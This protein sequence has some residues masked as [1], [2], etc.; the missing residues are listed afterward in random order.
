MPSPLPLEQTNRISETSLQK[1]ARRRRGILFLVLIVIMCGGLYMFVRPVM[2]AGV[3]PV[4]TPTQMLEAVAT[5]EPTKKV[6]VPVTVIVERVITATAA[7]TIAP[8]QTPYII[9][10]SVTLPTYTPYPTAT[11]LPA[12]NGLWFDSSGCLVVSIW[13]VREIYVT[14]STESPAVGGETYCDVREFRVVV[15]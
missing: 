14:Q 13:N 9:Y 1:S 4:V 6:V 7:P 12:L 10:K 8:T 3:S 11:P 2:F 5:M 15:R